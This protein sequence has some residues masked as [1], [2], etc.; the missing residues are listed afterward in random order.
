MAYRVESHINRQRGVP[1]PC[2][3]KR[4][5]QI[6]MVAFSPDTRSN[7]MGT[8]FTVYDHCVNPVKAQGLVEKA[9]TRQ[10]LAAI[11]YVSAVLALLGA[12]AW[13]F[14][15]V[16]HLQCSSL[17]ALC[18]ASQAQSQLGS[19]LPVYFYDPPLGAGIISSLYLSFNWIWITKCSYIHSPHTSL[20]FS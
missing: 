1:S 17:S 18:V 2:L 4:K 15:L 5:M 14:H 13:C 20:L 9:H 19:L 3:F 12:P 16:L 10:E 8:K 6:I 7:L 11:C